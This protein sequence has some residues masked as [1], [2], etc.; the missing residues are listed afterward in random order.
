MKQLISGIREVSKRLREIAQTHRLL[1][2][3]EIYLTGR[4]GLRTAFRQSS[5][6]A[7]LSGQRHYS[8]HPNCRKNPLST[9]RHQPTTARELCQAENSIA[10]STIALA[11]SSKALDSLRKAKLLDTKSESFCCI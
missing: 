4:G 2:G 8:L 1:F 9:L 5:H 10:C 3:G 6:L 7:G 11:R